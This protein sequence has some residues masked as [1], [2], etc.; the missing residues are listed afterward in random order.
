MQMAANFGP[1]PAP[2]N[3]L[4]ADLP[5]DGLVPPAMPGSA[6]SALAQSFINMSKEKGGGREGDEV[7]NTFSFLLSPH[8]PSK[9]EPS[10]SDPILNPLFSSHPI[11][12]VSWA[13]VAAEEEAATKASRSATGAGNRIQQDSAD[14]RATITTTCAGVVGTKL[15]QPVGRK[16]GAKLQYGEQGSGAIWPEAGREVSRENRKKERII[17]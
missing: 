12:F 2:T 17:Q 9:V 7:R 15:E 11:Q 16:E 4:L 8:L 13:L 1:A 3:S 14:K 5:T 6:R 10:F